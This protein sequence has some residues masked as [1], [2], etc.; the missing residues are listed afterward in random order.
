MYIWCSYIY[1]YIWCT[2]IYICI[3]DARIYM[4]V[5]IHTWCTYIS[6]Y[7][8]T[9][10][11]L[12][13][14]RLALYLYIPLSADTAPQ[15]HVN[16]PLPPRHAAYNSAFIARAHMCSQ[17]TSPPLFYETS[18]GAFTCFHT[19]GLGF[20]GSLEPFALAC[21]RVHRCTWAASAPLRPALRRA[22]QRLCSAL[23]CSALL[24]SPSSH[25]PRFT[26][27]FSILHFLPS[28][29]PKATLFRPRLTTKT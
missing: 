29:I 18:F 6:I 16:N 21:S 1:M 24:L 13:P 9:R 17:H 4:Y 27:F 19:S 22:F 28:P 12:F 5:Y 26:Q 25:N 3:Y 20:S 15:K 14:A 7:I 11:H 2:Y 10:T 8:C 23:L